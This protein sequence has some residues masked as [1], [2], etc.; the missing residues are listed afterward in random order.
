MKCMYI[1]FGHSNVE[2]LYNINNSIM[3]INKKNI[4]QDEINDMTNSW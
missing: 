1:L 2:M 4:Y 3:I